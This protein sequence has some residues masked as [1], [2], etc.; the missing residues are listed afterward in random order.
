MSTAPTNGTTT[1]G[2]DASRAIWAVGDYTVV[3]TRVFS[4]ADGLCELAD[5][6]GGQRVLDIAAGHGNATLCAARRDTEVT[7]VDVVPELLDAARSRLDTE[8]LDATVREGNAEALDFPDDSFDVV[9]SSLGLQFV[10]DQTAAAS[11]AL[12][13][14]RSGGRIAMASWTPFDAWSEL[15]P[16]QARYLPPPPDAPSP[17]VWGTEDGLRGL[18]GEAADLSLWP[19]TFRA[20]AASPQRYVEM[21]TAS[22]PPMV[23]LITAVGPDAAEDFRRDLL[24]LVRRWNEVDDGSLVL[25]LMYVVALVEVS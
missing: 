21:M 11:E 7:A 16:L 18:F 13:V 8:G 22:F 20:R 19:R 2:G 6:R 4:V 14:C 25:P 23:R 15:G 12:R 17:M 1:A 10:A 24:A 5:L 3:G 9:L